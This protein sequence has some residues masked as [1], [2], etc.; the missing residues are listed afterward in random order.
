[1]EYDLS[2]HPNGRHLREEKIGKLNALA[3]AVRHARGSAI[4]I[5]DDDNVLENVYLAEAAA[6]LKNDPALG[7][8]GGRICGEFE[9]PVPD[10]IR[11]FLRCL[12]INDQRCTEVRTTRSKN[13]EDAIPAGAGLVVRTALANS[14]MDHCRG[15]RVSLGSGAGGDLLAGSEDTDM[16]FDIIDQGYYAGQFPQLKATH[17]IPGARL[18][19]RYTARLRR[20][21]ARSEATVFFRHGLWTPHIWQCSLA[22][23]LFFAVKSFSFQ[24]AGK[25]WV[26]LNAKI[27]HWLAAR[28]Y[29]GKTRLWMPR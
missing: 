13:E 1:L 14:Y 2:W 20:H 4:V 15:Y 11:P 22:Y 18:T 6:I 21:R 16:V 10:C 27:G 24:D 9:W 3:L 26:E 5:V 17:I 29:F 19:L 23:P 28:D 7:A 12:A 25:W 8:F